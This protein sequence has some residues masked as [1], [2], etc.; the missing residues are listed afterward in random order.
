MARMINTVC[1]SVLSSELGTTLPHEHF[2]FG[3]PGWDGDSTWEFDQDA[4]IEKFTPLIEKL[5]SNYGLKTVVDATPNDNSR[6]IGLYQAI[7]RRFDLNI[8]CATG[9][10]YEMEG[11]SAYL[12]S[13]NSFVGNASDHAYELMKKELTEGIRNTGVKAGVIKLATGLNEITEYEEWLFRA[14]G[15]LGKENPDVRIITHTHWGHLLLEQARYLVDAGVPPSH[16]TIGHVDSCT[17]MDTLLSVLELGCYLSFDRFGLELKRIC[18]PLDSRRLAVICGLVGAGYGDKIVLSHDVSLKHLGHLDLTGGSPNW[19]W[20]HVF[21]N[22][23]P[24]LRKMGL[25]QEQVHKFMNENP[26]AF[27]G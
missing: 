24:Q 13:Y 16:I 19:H 6:N 22:I 27:Y 12:K 1:G 5:K 3:Y 26:Q 21:E 2:V 4:Y 8:I 23:L 25:S 11:A 18:C 9:Y 10:Y 20:L 15:R 17:D 7:S 14:A